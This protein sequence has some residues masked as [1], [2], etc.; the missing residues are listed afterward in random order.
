MKLVILVLI[1]ALALSIGCVGTQDSD[2]SNLSSEEQVKIVHTRNLQYFLY[3]NERAM[4]LA[5]APIYKDLGGGPNGDGTTTI[6]TSESWRVVFKDEAIKKIQ[7]K[8]MDELV[9]VSKATIHV[10][11][12]FS[13]DELS[14]VCA[15]QRVSFVCKDG[16]IIIMFP[17][18]EQSLLFDGWSGVYRKIDGNWKIVAGD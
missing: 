11:P 14:F 7:S 12:Q 5:Y 4:A 3:G 15:N 9:D 18:I 2:M 1:V 17:P 10:Y 16:D 6:N 8:D 13:K